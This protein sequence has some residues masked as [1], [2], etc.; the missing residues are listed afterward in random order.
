MYT[1]MLFQPAVGELH[2]QPLRAANVCNHSTDDRLFIS[3]PATQHSYLVDTGSVHCLIPRNL[4]PER[5]ERVNYELLAVND[6]TIA[7][8][9]WISLSL[10]LGL[11]RDFIWHFMVADVQDPIIGADLLAHFGLLVDLRNRRLL[12]GTSLSAPG[13][14]A[15]TS[16]PSAPPPPAERTTRSGRRV[17]LPAR[18][19]L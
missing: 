6:T 12:D 8:Y 16:I 1:A 19:E 9:G 10:D 7:T 11:R 14:V 3:D 13:H 17:R 4:H 2:Q 18:Y 5:N 15:P